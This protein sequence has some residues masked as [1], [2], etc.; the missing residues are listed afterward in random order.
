M[1]PGPFRSF[2]LNNPALLVCMT[3]AL[4]LAASCAVGPGPASGPGGVPARQPSPDRPCPAGTVSLVN[5]GLMGVHS[6]EATLNMTVS[7]KDPPFS[8]RVQAGLVAEKESRF[9]LR[10]YMGPAFVLDVAIARDSVWAY[11]PGNAEVFAG[12]VLEAIHAAPDSGVAYALAAASLGEVLFPAP[13]VP[14]SCKTTRLDATTCRLEERVPGRV[15]GEAGEVYP[16]AGD[17]PNSANPR[18]Y[19]EVLG[20]VASVEL[21][22]GRL[23]ELHLLHGRGA[24]QVSATYSDYRKT[25]KG[26]F[27][28]QIAVEFP[29]IGI[30][31][32]LVFDRV[33]VNPTIAENTYRVDVPEGVNVKR[34]NELHN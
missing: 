31:L 1:M 30:S 28:H 32:N 24:E 27:P 29:G 5:R 21:G 34:F 16:A 20:R 2:G 15:W 14:D 23:R 12:R 9:R 18:Y 3:A 6:I 26:I 22:K 11:L 7:V 33:K 25:G 4:L 10:A 8:T 13:F 17:R 19:F